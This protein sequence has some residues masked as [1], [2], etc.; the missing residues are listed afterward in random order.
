MQLQDVDLLTSLIFDAEIRKQM[1]KQKN[2]VL[3]K[4]KITSIHRSDRYQPHL[5]LERQCKSEQDFTK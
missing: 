5:L 1:L 3:E 4:K 2:V